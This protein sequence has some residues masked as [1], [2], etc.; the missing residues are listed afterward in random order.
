MT[1]DVIKQVVKNTMQ[2]YLQKNLVE[3]ALKR[4]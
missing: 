1:D 3:T 2:K 4:A